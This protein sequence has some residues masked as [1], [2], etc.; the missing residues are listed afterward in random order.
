[1]ETEVII[2]FNCLFNC[3]SI[4]SNY[5][6]VINLDLIGFKLDFCKL[7]LFIKYPLQIFSFYFVPNFSSYYF[8]KNS[9]YCL[10]Y[11]DVKPANYFVTKNL[12]IFIKELNLIYL[13]FI[14]KNLS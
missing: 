8:K 11:F 1:M 4:Y 3:Y 14:A 12:F 9:K 13:K 5:Q 7:N 2:R 10:V 6:P